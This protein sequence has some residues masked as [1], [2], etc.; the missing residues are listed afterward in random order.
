MA[1]AIFVPHHTYSIYNRWTIQWSTLPTTQSKS[2]AT[3]TA[4]I[5]KATKFPTTNFK[6]T[7]QNNPLRRNSISVLSLPKW[8]SWRGTQCMQHIFLWILTG[9]CIISRCSVLILWLIRIWR[10]CSLRSIRILVSSWV[11]GCWVGL[12]LWCWSRRLGSAWIHCFPRV[13][14]IRIIRGIWHR[15]VVWRNCRWS[16]YSIRGEMDRRWVVPTKCMRRSIERCRGSYK[17]VRKRRMR[18]FRT[19]GRRFR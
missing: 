9:R 2:K 13:C 5:N 7:S 3:I 10:W 14:I 17:E 8:S 18:F 12:Y 1:K 15:I 16:W 4:A 11:V 6:N 19:K